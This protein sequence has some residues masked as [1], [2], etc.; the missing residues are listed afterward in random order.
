M[1]AVSVETRASLQQHCP[2][3]LPFLQD[4]RLKSILKL[5]VISW[6]LMLDVQIEL[7]NGFAPSGTQGTSTASFVVE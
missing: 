1:I 7:R 4:W 3:M 2:Q 6:L 5:T